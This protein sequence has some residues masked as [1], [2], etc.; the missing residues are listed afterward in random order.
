MTK[1]EILQIFKDTNALLNGHFILTSGLH[2]AQYFQCAQVLK[3]P[4]LAEKLCRE[5]AEPFRE[6]EID[7]VIAPAVGGI[8]V[9]HEVARA[10]GLPALFAERQNG[11]MA[12]RRNFELA[13]NQKALIVEDVITTGGSVKEVI[14]LVKRLGAEPVGV[15]S[16][17]DRSGGKADFGVPFH[18]LTSLQ[19]ET[20]Q[21]DD[22]YLKKLEPAVKPGSRSL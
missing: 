6:I 14:E 17:V 19:I 9:S 10:L 15:G 7:L 5:M 22:P 20:Y 3:H 18:P 2:S 12:L 16:I 11:K 8:V 13:P 4:A 1:D 21:A